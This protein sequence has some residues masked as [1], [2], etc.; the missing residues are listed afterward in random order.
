[1]A[2]YTRGTYN[3][4]QYFFCYNF[5]FR[6]TNECKLGLKLFYTARCYN[7][8]VYEQ[9]TCTNSAE[10]I[11]SILYSY[12][13]QNTLK[14]GYL[15]PSS[16][17]QMVIKYSFDLHQPIIIFAVGNVSYEASQGRLNV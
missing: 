9:R 14:Y 8:F 16:N 17:S 1:M 7:E 6:I 11:K 12:P 10:N 4:F 2:I 15:H 13:N 3:D 5:I